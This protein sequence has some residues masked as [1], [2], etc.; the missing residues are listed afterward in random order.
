MSTIKVNNVIPNTGDTVNVN[1]ILITDGVLSATTYQNLPTVEFTGGTVYGDTEFLGALTASTIFANTYENLPVTQFT[2]GTVDGFTDFVNGLSA[3]TVSA[4]TFYGDGSN[5]TGIGTVANL[6]PV[7]YSELIYMIDEGMLL[8]GSFYL[9]SDFKTCYD[10]P[11]YYADGTIKLSGAT[12]YV[13][14]PIEPIIVLAISSSAISSSAYQP[15]YPND[16]I[17]YDWRWNQTEISLGNAYGRITERI[18][19]FN[20]RTDYDHRTIE[21][22][23]FETFNKGNK[24]SGVISAFNC[25]TGVL[26][27][28]G[29]LFLSEVDNGDVLLMDWQNGLLG[30]KVI[31][32]STDTDLV[33]IVDPT[34]TPINFEGGLISFYKGL[35]IEEFHEYKESFIGQKLANNFITVPTFNL[36]GTAIHNYIG[37][38]SKFYIEGGSSNSGFLLA[39]NVFYSENSRNYSNTIGDRSYNNNFTYWFSRNT[40]AGRFY[41]NVARQNGFYSNSIGEYFNNNKIMS[42][43]YGNIINEGFEGNIIISSFYD[44]NLGGGFNNNTLFSQFYGNKIG[45]YFSYNNIGDY[46]NV[47]N[48]EFYRNVIGNNFNDNIIRQTFQNN[49]IGNQFHDNI[50]NG[51]FIKNKIGNG[52][53]NNQN[54]GSDFIGNHIGDGFNYNDLIGDNFED[55]KIGNYF[56]N[57]SISQNF[58]NNK[59]NDNFENNTLGDTQ[60]FNWENL[61]YDNLTGRTYSSFYNSLDGNIGNIILGKELIMHDMVNDEYHAIKFTQWTQSGNG[62]GFSYERTMVWPSEGPT[63][64]F[65]KSNYGSEIDV[66]YSGSVEITR[67]DNG[68]IYNAAVQGSWN[69]SAPENTEWNSIYT[70]YNTGS[71][72]RN[73]NINTEFKGNHIRNEFYLNDVGSYVGSNHFSGSTSS[74]LIGSYTFD[75]DF[76]G[77]TNGNTWGNGFNGNV[78]GDGFRENTMGQSIYGNIIGFNFASNEIKNNFTNNLINDNFGYG[79]SSPQGNKI[80]NNFYNNNIGEY[81]YNNIIPDN[82]SSNIIGNLF[83]WNVIKTVIDENDFTP[84]YGNVTA[85]TYTSFAS[86][87]SD[88]LYS[89]IVGTSNVDGVGASFDIEVSGGTV[90][91]FSGNSEG[92]LYII[93]ETILISGNQINGNLDAVIGFTSDAIGKTGVTGIY[94]NIFP[95][96]T[97]TGENVS[98]D[99]NVTD[100]LVDEIIINNG[101]GNYTVGEELKILGSVFGGVDGDDDINIIVQTTHSDDIMITVTGVSLTPSVYQPYTA[102]IFE[103][104]GGDKR[105]SFYDESDILN[106]TNINE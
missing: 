26:V 72:F 56:E 74:N 39:N 16:R 84:N 43:V 34:F 70:Q 15:A 13:E 23:R 61:S 46:G 1:G 87:A 47:D 63:V 67:G 102:E 24:L 8:N 97:G 86:T 90:I 44:N 5:L 53:N 40:I 76:L 20:N 28:E 49:T 88:G 21:F 96:G 60:Y 31:S 92:K 33:V 51:N 30:V 18:D 42:Q 105:L 54:I 98:F 91:G 77:N 100:N 64:Y 85:F 11:E 10:R 89:D 12:T 38:Y 7:T 27:G 73:N 83:Q 93:G 17:Q 101:G 22:I 25:L 82:F 106:I 71:N 48:F 69:G 52:F 57:N 78:I 37:D 2:G 75:N 99:I 41:N 9:I 95:I 45:N 36:D 94:P 79:Y 65:T 6:I 55:N 103:R 68:G 81:F 32:A 66:I 59:I 62:G 50:A 80:G 29:T 14:G 4:T 19:E 3:T 35:N 104:K 58:Q